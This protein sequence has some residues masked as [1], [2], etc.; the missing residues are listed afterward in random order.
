MAGPLTGVRVLDFT[1]ALAGPFGTMILADLG[2]DVVLVSRTTERDDRSRGPGPYVRDRS[3]YRFSI[4]RGK[5]NIQLDLKDSTGAEIALRLAERSDVLAENFTPGTMDKLGLGYEAVSK[6]NPRIIYAS[7][8][9]HGQTGPYAGKGAV[10]IVAQAMSG[11]MSI[12]GEADGR[13]MRV[14]ASFG[15]TIGGNYL[16]MGVIAA[17]YERERSGLGQR[18]DV[19]MVETVMYHMENAIIRYSATAEVPGRI[20]PRHPLVTPFQPFHTRD[21]WIVVAAVRDW[22]AFCVVIGLEEL[23]R[24]PRFVTNQDRNVHHAELEVILD[25]ALRARTSREWL[26]L[27]DTTC[28]VC[29]VYDVAQAIDDPQIRARRAVVEVPMALADGQVKSVLLPNTPVRLSRTPAE[30][31]RPAPW[32]GE[33]TR[34]VL[35]DVLQMSLEEIDELAR[36]GVIG[37]RS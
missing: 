26:G 25:E 35:R 13:P 30:V 18:L 24:D 11:L 36:R 27:L 34:V 20:G 4:E 17:L 29:P 5:R 37:C 33:D 9:G 16:A 22:E 32:V 2:A 21:G 14:G 3:T 15:D 7:V 8:S 28:I 1:H 23:A 6:R 12:T 31:G 10:D 19:S